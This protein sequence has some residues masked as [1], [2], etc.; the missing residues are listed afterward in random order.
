MAARVVG[1]EYILPLQT[2]SKPRT[3]ME[4]GSSAKLVELPSADLVTLGRLAC[5][6]S[7]GV[8]CLLLFS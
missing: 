3:Y 6:F 4:P 7:I 5:S 1:V 8:G 2:A